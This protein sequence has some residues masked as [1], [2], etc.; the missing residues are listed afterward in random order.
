M[1][2]S[3]DAAKAR[4]EAMFRVIAADEARS[5]GMSEYL[6]KQQAELDKTSRLRALRLARDQSKK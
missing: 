4:A 5:D 6:A 2:E 3:S 1:G